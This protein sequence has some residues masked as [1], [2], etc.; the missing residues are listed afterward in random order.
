[1]TA[2]FPIAL[3]AVHGIL[4]PPSQEYFRTTREKMFGKKL[5]EFA[6]AG[7]VR[8]GVWKQVKEGL[9]KLASF[10][11]ENDGDSVLFFKDT[12]A[13]ADTIVIGYLLWAK[14]SLGADSEE[15]KTMA[16]WNNGRWERLLE[17]TKKLYSEE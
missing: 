13:F 15:W 4:N 12:F 8:D 6:P 9:D 3:P 16:S 2:F 17:S 7:L 1:M 11:D 5:E 10:Y 14:I